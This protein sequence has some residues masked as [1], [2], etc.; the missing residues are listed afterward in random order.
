MGQDSP[1]RCAGCSAPLPENARFCPSCGRLVTAPDPGPALAPTAFPATQPGA[2]GLPPTS[3][4]LPPVRLLPGTEI[5]VYR[6]ESTLGEGGM[7]VVYRAYDRAR[8]RVV[9]V[10]CLHSN[11]CGNPEIR[12]RFA[13]EARVLRSWSH[14]NVVA[15]YDFVER[16][17]LLAIVMEYV[18]G[19]TLVR[20]L[21]RWRGRIPF[22]EIRALFGGVLEAMDEGH[23]MGII[24]RDLKPDNI[25]VTTGKDGLSPKIVDFGIAKILEGTTYTLSGAFLGT[26]CYMSPEQVKSPH[27]ADRRSDIYSLG[28]TLYKLTTGQVPFDSPNHF[29]VMMAHVADAPAPPSSLRPDI[30]PALDRLVLDALSKDPAGR[31]AS[32]AEFRARL[33]EALSEFSPAPSRPSS[34]GRELAPTVREKTGEQMILVPGGPFLSG[35]Q[36]RK[37]H[38]DAF[39]MDR[40]PVTNRQFKAFLDVTGYRP[41]DD[42]ASRLLAHFRRGEIPAGLEDHPVVYVSWDDARAYANWAGKRLPTEAEWEKA[43]RGTDGRK[44][45]WGRAEP[46]PTR[47]NYDNRE[48]GTVPVGSLPGGASPYGILDLAGNVWEWCEDYDDPHFYADGPSHNPR[49][50]RP[51]DRPLLV[52]RG[53]SWMYGAQSLRT[54]ARTSFEAHYRF[55]G[56]GFRCVRTASAS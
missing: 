9:A 42:D 13:R 33:D 4:P 56:G 49:N 16:D 19:S 11:L 37:V 54:W 52:M 35:Q 46:G 5:S 15:V 17:H 47:A 41:D 43:A 12:R 34:D 18:D 3:L 23:R 53:G 30:P 21:E 25:L 31:P 28:V 51:S 39:Y 48:G 6:I 36:R 27:A 45:P 40:T 44:Y 7:G 50:T 20:H 38:V 1:P 2:V 26:C 22:Q 8:E 29:A 32:C 24:H 10:K 55:A 14:D